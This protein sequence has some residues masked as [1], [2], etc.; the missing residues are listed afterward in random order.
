MPR[1]TISLDEMNLHGQGANA[2]RVSR[3]QA[4]P[5]YAA[6]RPKF[7]KADL[8]DEAES[9]WKEVVKNLARRRTLTSGDGHLITLY[10]G[11]YLQWVSAIK[12]VAVSGVMIEQTRVSKSG[13]PYTVR[14]Q[15]PCVR[16]AASLADRL[17][18]Y[19]RDLGLTVKDREKITPLPKSATAPQEVPGTVAYAKKHAND[20]EQAPDLS[21]DE[22]V[23]EDEPVKE[24]ANG[25]DEPGNDGAQ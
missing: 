7:P 20:S 25:N 5:S 10:C 16:M 4:R 12:E 19:L 6:G 24:E 11:T 13:E 15:N 18:E 21:V 23:F 14:I 3:A 9:V 8:P 22:I 2:N 1:P 17:Q